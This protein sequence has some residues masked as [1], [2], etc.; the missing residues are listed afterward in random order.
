MAENPKKTI[1]NTVPIDLTEK[2]FNEF[3]LPTLHIPSR[4]SSPKLSDYTVFD[5]ILNFMHTG[6]QWKKELT[7]YFSI[8][9]ISLCLSRVGL[10]IFD[11]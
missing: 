6:C 8:D 5:Y 10:R 3:V 7:A 9:I 4:G 1:W 11:K 2:E